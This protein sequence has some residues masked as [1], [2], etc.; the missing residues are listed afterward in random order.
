MDLDV[1]LIEWYQG[2]T[3]EVLPNGSH[4]LPPTRCT[5]AAGMSVQVAP[6]QCA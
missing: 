3:V 1:Y 4:V 2:T 6:S 5:G